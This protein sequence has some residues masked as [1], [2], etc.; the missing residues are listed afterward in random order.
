MKRVAVAFVGTLLALSMPSLGADK[1]TPPPN[2]GTLT[3]AEAQAFY[4]GLNAV[5]WGYPVVMS[6]EFMRARTHPDIVKLGNPQSAVNQFGLVREL[7]GPEYK[8]IATPTTIRFMPKPSAMSAA[9]R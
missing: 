1:R 8:Q 3:G 5:I 4:L 7:R 2:L 6:E 9:S